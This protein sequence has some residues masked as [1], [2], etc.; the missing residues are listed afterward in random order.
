MRT[1]EQWNECKRV[2][3]EKK[4]K[5]FFAEY[6]TEMLLNESGEI[7]SCVY[8]VQGECG[9]PIK[10]GCSADITQRFL[11]LQV[12]CQEKLKVLLVIPGDFAKEA[13]LHKRFSEHRLHGEWFNP[14][15]EIL[16]RI[17]YLKQ[18]YRKEDRGEIMR[19]GYKLVLAD[20]IFRDIMVKVY[21]KL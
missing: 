5:K 20:R 6:G 11:Q 8:C 16:E 18:K 17:E 13:S 9:G 1:E 4:S 14:A 19:D 15:P 21:R 7:A 2:R 3:L 10:I 12:K